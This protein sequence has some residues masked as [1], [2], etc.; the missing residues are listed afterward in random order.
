MDSG[1]ILKLDGFSSSS[2]VELNR[3]AVEK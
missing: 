3:K 2:V 1:K